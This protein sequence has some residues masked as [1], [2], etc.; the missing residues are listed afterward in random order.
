MISVPSNLAYQSTLKKKKIINANHK[1]SQYKNHP[2]IQIA[3]K[4]HTHRFRI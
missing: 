3:L 4:Y 1:I 2:Q